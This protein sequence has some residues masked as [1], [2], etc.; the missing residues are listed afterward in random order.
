MQRRKPDITSFY[1][2]E[3]KLLLKSLILIFL[4]HCNPDEINRESTNE[5][6]KFLFKENVFKNLLDSLE[7][8]IGKQLDK[9]RDNLQ[10]QEFLFQKLE[11]EEQLLQ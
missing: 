9:R 11:E 6:I 2:N 4:I 10:K 5:F 1:Y 7:G 8:N 3:R